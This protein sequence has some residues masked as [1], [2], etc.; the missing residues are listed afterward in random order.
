MIALLAGVAL[1][2]GFVLAAR[3]GRG[4]PVRWLA[5]AG[6]AVGGAGAFYWDHPPFVYLA[7]LLGYYYALVMLVVFYA[8]AGVLVGA[9]Y[10]YLA[11]SPG[12]LRR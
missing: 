4:T 9:V 12:P 2:G 5:W 3:G 8:S 1:V 10:R 11:R 7:D 6:V